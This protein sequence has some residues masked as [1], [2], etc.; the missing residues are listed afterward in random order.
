MSNRH[1]KEVAGT[2]AC[3]IPFC[4][5]ARAKL[6]L[7]NLF[8]TCQVLPHRR[9]CL[10]VMPSQTHLA[11]AT[12]RPRGCTAPHPPRSQT[13]CKGLLYCLIVLARNPVVQ[14]SAAQDWASTPAHLPLLHSL[15]LT[16]QSCRTQ[17]TPPSASSLGPEVTVGLVFSPPPS[18]PL[19]RPA[20]R[21]SLRPPTRRARRTQTRLS[22]PFP[23]YL[24]PRRLR[25]QSPSGR[26]LRAPIHLRTLTVR[27]P[28]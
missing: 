5:L 9:A 14:R 28:P 6:A 11:L 23:L 10:R 2:P 25:G 1:S 27:N 8:L 18:P 12:C 20:G 17:I 16:G 7:A 24:P 13:S 3:A 21:P 26:P 15:L 4:P 19:R 22:L